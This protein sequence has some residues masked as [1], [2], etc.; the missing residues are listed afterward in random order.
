VSGE[1]TAA[2]D[3]AVQDRAFTPRR[4]LAGYI[5]VLAFLAAGVA[6][7]LVLGHR[8]HAQ[9]AVAGKYASSAACLS[10]FTLKQSG[11]FVDVSGPGS[12]GGKLRLEHHR[13]KGDVT[14]GDGATAAINVPVPTTAPKTLSGTLGGQAFQAK[15]TAALPAPGASAKPAK[16]RSGEETFGR[17]MLAIAAVILAARLVGTA[18]GKI[19]QP[20]VMGEVL[21]GILLGPTLLGAVL[22]DV[23]DY[24]F[25]GDIVPLLSGAA[26]IGLAFYLF[27]VGMELDPRLLRVNA[28]RAAFVSNTSVAVPMALGML[29]A[30]PIYRLLAPHKDYLPFALFMGV[31]MSITAFPVLAR[32]LVERRMLKRPVGALAMA[33]AA[34]DD[35]TAWTLLAFATAVASAGS[36]LEWLRVVGLATAFTLGLVIVVRP[37]LARVAVAYDEVGYVPQLWIGTI[38]VGVLLS[39][40]VAREIG[41]AAI[42]G[43]FVMGLIMPRHAGLTADVSRRLE[44]FVTM[45][46]LPLFF[47]VTGLKTQ[48]GSLNRPVL[49]L[50][51]VLLIGVAI[52]GKWFGAM[53]AARWGGM[54]WRDSAAF[55]ALMN[56]RGLTELIVL[57]IGLDLGLISP[58]LFTML[59]VMALVT[60]FMAGPALRLLDPKEELSETPEEEFRRARLA[61]PMPET[62][63]PQRS[64]IVAPQDDK[65][66]D[67]LIALAEPLARS[68]PPRELILVRL[69][70][71]SNLATGLRADDRQLQYATDELNQRRELLSER[72]VQSRAVAFTSPDPGSDLVRLSTEQD[73]DLLIMNGRRPLIGEGVPRGDVGTVLEKAPCDVAV[74]V[75]R[76]GIPTIDADHPVFVPFGGAEHDWA[77]LELAAWIAS[78]RE[79]PLKLLGAS[80]GADGNGSGGQRDASRLIGNASLVV[81]QLAGIAAEPVLVAPGPQVIE[82]ARSAGL[83]VIGLSERW[84]Q[85][86]LG[87]VRSEIAKTAPAPTLFVRR[88]ERPGT[89]A[90][91]E[92]MTRFRWSS[93][94][95]PL[96][97]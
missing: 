49:W 9:P 30:A 36:S 88:G 23:K 17:L 40:Y 2:P 77:A 53:A 12:I 37:L 39:A 62:V 90:P 7:S 69:V 11:T 22:P 72:G 75:E 93:A 35:V 15:F 95:P 59:V 32:I 97:A 58:A 27:L 21:A 61:G 80:A 18:L 44:D 16:K 43:A 52:A 28:A 50:L 4:L 46:L 92:D 73:V 13:L 84:R 87:P 96:K 25:P 70:L 86:G 68:Q 14:C 6:L 45:V 79:A 91:K 76:E 26:Q 54:R 38:F 31:S 20:R 10:S 19:G 85:E 82:A 63:G 33:S 1:L 29:V 47:V 8:E 60:T 24:L 67:A 83:L 48:V 71:P 94:G 78:V 57:N 65:N 41:I 89:L 42:F 55:G 64:I 66:T 5:A 56:T 51:C 74:L 34:I 3:A 81:Q